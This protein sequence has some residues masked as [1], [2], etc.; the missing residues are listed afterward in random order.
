VAWHDPPGALA[1]RNLGIAEVNVGERLESFLLVSQGFDWL[2]A[3]W[4]NFP[5]DTAVLT[6]LGTALMESGHGAEAAAAFE[7]AIQIEPRVAVRYLHAGLAWKVAHDN[8]KAGEY[9]EK[10][11]QLDPLLDQPYRELADIYSET[12]D[13]AMLRQTLERYAKAFPKR[14]RAQAAIREN[15]ASPGL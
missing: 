3:C 11:I 4:D 13:G 1:K 14:I 9:F 12:H 7:Q 6:G 10:T 15:G 5:N 8:A 2:M